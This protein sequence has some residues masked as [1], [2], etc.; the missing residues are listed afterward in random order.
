MEAVPDREYSRQEVRVAAGHVHLSVRPAHDRKAAV[1]QENGQ[2]RNVLG[3]SD[4]NEHGGRSRES[5]L[6][7]STTVAIGACSTDRSARCT[8]EAK[9]LEGR[10][11]PK[12]VGCVNSNL[13]GTYTHRSRCC[14]VFVDQAAEA[15]ASVDA[16]G[17]VRVAEASSLVRGWRRQLECSM[18]PVAVVMIDIDAE[19]L[20]ELSAADDQDPVEAVTS[21]G[22]DPA[23]GKRV[24]LRGLERCADHL[25]LPRS[26]RSRRSRE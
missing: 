16:L 9:L 23:L 8:A 25:Q 11:E 2:L 20:L 21:D 13:W 15:I 4:A 7:R 6:W 12:R 1:E 19:H 18:R 3:V 24:R 22:P 26:G 5:N 14:G 17:W 10:R